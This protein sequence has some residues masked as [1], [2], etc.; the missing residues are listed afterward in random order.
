MQDEMLLKVANANAVQVPGAVGGMFSVAGAGRELIST[1]ITPSGISAFLPS[2][3]SK[4][5]R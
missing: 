2:Q 1:F 4:R 3:L 5:T